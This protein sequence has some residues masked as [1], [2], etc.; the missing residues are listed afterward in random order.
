MPLDVNLPQPYA[1]S[2]LLTEQE[3]NQIQF[4]I[5]SFE[6]PD[7]YAQA[8]GIASRVTGLSEALANAGFETH[9][10][11]VG[12]PARPGHETKD[13]L[14]LHRWCQWISHYYSGGV[15]EGE[16][17]KRADFVHSLPPFLLQEVLLP[18]LRKTGGQA[19]V[20]AE[21]WQTV[22]A[23]LHLDWL[24]RNAGVRQQVSIF[25]NANNTFGFERINWY[26]LAE[27]AVITTVSRYMRHSINASRNALCLAKWLVGTRISAGCWLLRRLVN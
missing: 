15:Y 7:G 16:E 11:F 18:Y 2:T 1:G 4:H 26:R 23:V 24:L 9:L 14:R 5:I 8:G 17:E 25:W 22:D 3:T 12:D 13:R 6:G 20:L 10:W 21:E 27:A 19:V